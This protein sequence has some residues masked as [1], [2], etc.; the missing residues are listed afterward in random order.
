MEIYKPIIY[1][2]FFTLFDNL[3]NLFFSY[4]KKHFPKM[5][6]LFFKNTKMQKLKLK[7]IKFRDF[8]VTFDQVKKFNDIYFKNKH[9]FINNKKNILYID[10]SCLL[11]TATFGGIKRTVYELSKIFDSKKKDLKY[12]IIFFYFTKTYP[13][14]FREV[15]FDYIEKKKL[16]NFNSKTFY[17]KYNSKFLFLDFNISGILQ[18]KKLLI[19]MKKK[20]NLNY[21]FIVYDILPFTNPEWFPVR[22]YKKIFFAWINF[23]LKYG[24]VLTISENVKK[25]IIYNFKKMCFPRK[26]QSFMLGGNFAKPS[27][28]NC[29]NNKI[30]FLM[31]GTLEPRKGHID[32]IKSFEILYDKYKDIELIIIGNM[33]WKYDKIISTLENSK[34]NGSVIKYY[35]NV[36]DKKLKEFYEYA[37][38]ILCASYDEGC[39]LPILEG[40]VNN[41]IVIA[42]N[43]PVFKEIGKTS[44]YYFPNSDYIKISK[45]L[46]KWIYLF[47]I[48][49][50][51]KIKKHKFKLI[52][53]RESFEQVKKIIYDN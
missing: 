11:R 48:K 34:L 37:T 41:K 17:P 4:F 31:V 42:R 2:F 36:S 20:L 25:N 45:F 43:I 21:Y 26:I 53:W 46:D 40:L 16:F 9:K 39:G 30:T 50:N 49:K 51:K 10:V 33:G 23:V 44:I 14:E 5:Y 32:I 13:H 24:F 18:T 19:E 12:K 47:K 29:K 1:R 3:L 35:S 8:N 38:I 15:D 52:S 7:Y 6:Y 27:N 22:N 28:K